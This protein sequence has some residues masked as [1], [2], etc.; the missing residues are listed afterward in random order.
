M[1]RIL[2]GIQLSWS[3]TRDTCP[4]CI[5]CDNLD[6]NCALFIRRPNKD[7]IYSG[8]FIE[9]EANN[10]NSTES[11]KELP[12]RDCRKKE[13]NIAYKHWPKVAK[14]LLARDCKTKD[15]E[16][17]K[18]ERSDPL[19]ANNFYNKTLES[20]L[21]IMVVSAISATTVTS[22]VLHHHV[23]DS[24]TQ[25]WQQR[26]AKKKPFVKVHVKVCLLY[27]SPSPRD[28]LLSRMPSSA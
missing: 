27:T 23:F 26:Q 5:T 21:A 22:D 24:R 10:I 16:N 14:K 17:I 12:A 13:V 8:V 6:N 4:S 28:G 2:P 25:S 15:G 3:Q 7:F 11:V 20:V 18:K 19:P 9:K 1:V